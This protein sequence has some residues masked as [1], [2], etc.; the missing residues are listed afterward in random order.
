MSELL[1]TRAVPVPESRLDELY[2]QTV[3]MQAQQAR[4]WR[5]AA[6]RARWGQ[7]GLLALSLGL[8]T[9]VL[10]MLPLVRY[11]PVFVF[12]NAAGVNDTATAISDL[13]PSTQVAGIEG[14]PVAVSPQPR[15]LQS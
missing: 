13:P 11:V 8:G 14:P 3:S 1:D 5:R 7:A 10:A 9:A 12:T 6:R 15:A 2:A 4:E